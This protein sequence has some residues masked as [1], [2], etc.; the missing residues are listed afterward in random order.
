MRNE[1][2]ARIFENI[3]VMLQIQEDDR[4]KIR[5]YQNGAKVMRGLA[6]DVNDLYT[7]EGKKGLIKING[8]GDALSDKIIEF[9]KTKK[10]KEY[11]SLKKK[12]PESVVELTRVPDVGPKTAWSL[13]K[14]F[15]IN[16]ISKLEKAAK[17]HA[18]SQLEGFRDKTE[19]N[20]LRGIKQ[21][22]LS[23]KEKHR[24]LYSKAKKFADEALDYLKKNKNIEKIEVVG[25]LRRKEKTIGDVDIVIATKQPSKI[26][27]YFS[28]APFIDEILLQGD[29]KIS[30]LHKKGP[31]VDLEVLPKRDWGSLLQ[32][33]TGSKSHNVKLRTWAVEHG[34]SISEHGIKVL[35]TG[36]LQH[37]DNEKDL[38]GFL[39]MKYIKPEDRKG[40]K[41]VE[42]AL[43]Q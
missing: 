17:N 31:R 37:F 20:I 32:H 24:M 35:S 29:T 2:I 36:K 21:Y 39:G 7:K 26:I 30:I 27:K 33:F 3:A 16:S 5:A 19:E 43:K 6:F 11:E 41:E 12:I 1:K 4:F 34:Y 40:G 14:E 8:I 42:R 22:R 9:I 18:I 23:L 15:G 25:S 38:Y 13:Y 10:I 28:K